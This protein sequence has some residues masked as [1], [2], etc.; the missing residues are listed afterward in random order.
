MIDFYKLRKYFA[1]IPLVIIVLGIIMF[2]INGFNYGIDF[3]GGTVIR[4][5]AGK[6]IPEDEV[7]DIARKV[8]PNI[9]VVYAGANKEQI[10]IKSTL[11]LSNQQKSEIAKAF[12]EK[13][14]I[15]RDDFEDTSTGPSVSREIKEKAV[16][17]IILASILMLVYVSIRFQWKYG[18]AAVLA[19][20]C[21]TFVVLAAY[22]IFNLSID[23]S[24]IA[25]V[26]TIVGYSINDTIVIFDRFR[27]NKKLHPRMSNEEVINNSL[28]ST[29]RRTILTSLTTLMAVLVLYFLGGHVIRELCLP[30]I[31]GLIEGTYSSIFIAPTIW[32][33]LSKKPVEK[34]KA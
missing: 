19:L 22:G 18:V 24:L 1:P 31:I 7:Y 3:S 2:S 16:I 27:E 32:D 29:L 26:L 5:N 9:G 20:V 12:E 14:K 30:L 33:W 25:A 13:Y 6:F 17:S 23:S 8:D 28:N 21:D 15:S 10:I 34:K 4:V 11:S